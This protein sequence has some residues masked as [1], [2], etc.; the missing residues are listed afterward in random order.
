[1]QDPFVARVTAAKVPSGEVAMVARKTSARFPKF[2]VHGGD[3]YTNFGTQRAL[4]DLKFS[5]AA[6]RFEAPVWT[7]GNLC[8]S[9]KSAALAARK[10]GAASKRVERWP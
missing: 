10:P 1:L 9:F 6:F 2:V 7:R 8:R 4:A 3:D 5:G